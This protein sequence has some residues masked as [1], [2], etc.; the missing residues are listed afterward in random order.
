MKRLSVSASGGLAIL[1]ITLMAGQALAEPIRVVSTTELAGSLAKMIGGNQVTVES[2][3]RGDQDPHYVNPRPSQCTPLNKADLLVAI[4]QGLEQLWLSELVSQC[5]NSR[6]EEG[7][8]GY[9]DL[10]RGVKLLP[11]P[12]RE[13]TPQGWFS[14]LMGR[15]FLGPIE[16][17]PVAGL[18]SFGNPQYWLDPANGDIMARNISAKLASM[19][20]AHAD[21]YHKNYEAFAARLQ[22]RMNAWDTQMDPFRGMALAA[23]GIGWAYLAER[24]DLKIVSYVEP[25]ESRTLKSRQRSALIELMQAHRVSLLLMEPYQDQGAAHKI[26]QKIGAEVL[27]LPTSVDQTQ[28]ITDHIQ[29]FEVIYE[30]LASNLTESIP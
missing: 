9:L 22:E 4:G 13:E 8:E 12:E 24:H 29:M 10:S 30:R 1:F 11:L 15:M 2:L 23:Y 28:G 7:G 17:G 25:T 14:R 19:D 20:P 6:V 26:A 18:I 5:R 16:T 27:V 21:Q 3:V